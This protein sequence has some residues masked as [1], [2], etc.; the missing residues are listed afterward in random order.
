MSSGEYD[1]FLNIQLLKNGHSALLVFSYLEGGTDAYVKCML[2]ETGASFFSTTFISVVF[3]FNKYFMR[4]PSVT[5]QTHVGRHVK[6]P[7]KLET[8]NAETI[9][10]KFGSRVLSCVRTDWTKKKT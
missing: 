2:H 8:K 9:F 10:R 1:L 4:Y 5:R 6:W 3:A 7:L